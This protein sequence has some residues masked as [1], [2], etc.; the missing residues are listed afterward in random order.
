ME[1]TEVVVVGS[2]RTGSPLAAELASDPAF[3]DTARRGPVA[4][5]RSRCRSSR[6]PQT[7]PSRS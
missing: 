4:A 5:T 6:S 2:G 1:T 7:V 3:V